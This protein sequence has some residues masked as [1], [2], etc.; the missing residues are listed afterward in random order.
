MEIQN[1]YKE[2]LALFNAHGVKYV[3][4]GA[5]ALAFH[6]APRFTGD[7]DLFI[8]PTPDNAARILAALR[9]FGFGD[10]GLTEDDFIQPDNVI[11]LGVPPIRIN[12]LTSIDGVSWSE[13]VQG[14]VA[15]R[16][17]DISVHF[18]GKDQYIRNKQ[19][20]GRTKDIADIE[21]LQ[22]ADE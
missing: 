17:A 9:D 20:S 12:L 19:A 6:G 2:L 18:I 4:A 1:D 21:A 13:V 8:Q 10:V 3:V 7:I 16:Y 5:Y 15:G 11:Q 22:A 14:K